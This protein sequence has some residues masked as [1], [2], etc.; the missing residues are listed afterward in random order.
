MAEQIEGRLSALVFVTCPVV[1]RLVFLERP[2]DHLRRGH[3]FGAGLLLDPTLSV[4]VDLQSPDVGCLFNRHDVGTSSQQIIPKRQ[5]R[6]KMVGISSQHDVLGKVFDAP[7]RVAD[8]PPRNASGSR[9][10]CARTG[11]CVI[12]DSTPTRGMFSVI[13]LEYR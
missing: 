11:R 3:A 1:D 8:A 6:D 9:S 13:D 4:G 12:A 5:P 10:G 2:A 7:A